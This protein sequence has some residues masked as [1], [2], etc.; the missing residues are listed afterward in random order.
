MI[1]TAFAKPENISTAALVT[2]SGMRLVIPQA[3]IR[4]LEAA[5]D[6]DTQD[7]EPFSVGWIQYLEERWP[8]FCL[9]DNL[10]LLTNIPKERRACILMANAKGYMG[11]LCDEVQIARQGDL[12]EQHE[13]PSTMRQSETPILGLVTVNQDYVGCLT[14]ANE[15]VAHI[16][17][18]VDK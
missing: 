6:V 5:A 17:R 9:S 7:P 14:S 13:L 2:I 16:T 11:F 3:D 10:A 4:A 12:G 8:T 15:L 1:S 18:L